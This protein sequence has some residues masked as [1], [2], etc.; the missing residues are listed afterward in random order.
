ML[1][2]GTVLWVKK[3]R[4]NSPSAIRQGSQTEAILST[5]TTLLLRICLC[6]SLIN[7]LKIQVLYKSTF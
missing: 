6:S 7:G 4:K 5:T 3:D 2:L 1:V